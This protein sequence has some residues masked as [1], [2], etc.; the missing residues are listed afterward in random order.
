M[1]ISCGGVHNV[2]L[3]L[4]DHYLS[5]DLYKNLKNFQSWDI[6]IFLENSTNNFKIKCHKYV[7]I[8]RSIYFFKK[9]IT[10]NV[11]ILLNNR[12]NS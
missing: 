6:E 2:C 7:L 10:D 8:S 12:K 5:Y 9:L 3:S 1:K 4:D 11:K